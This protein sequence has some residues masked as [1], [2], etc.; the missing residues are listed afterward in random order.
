VAL[1][2]QAFE[3]IFTTHHETLYRYAF[4]ILRDE[5]SAEEAVS[6]VFCRLWQKRA[7]LPADSTLPGYVYSA[8][9]HEAMD[10][11]KHEEI[12][13]RHTNYLV[14]RSRQVRQVAEAAHRA[15]LNE[16]QQLLLQAL[17]NLPDQ[18]RLIFHLSRVEQL[19]HKDIAARLGLSIKTV[20]T[21]VGRAL[22]RLRI[23]LADYLPL[24]IIG[25]VVIAK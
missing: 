4:S 17:E 22:K 14:Y 13:K 10:Q 6:A 25:Y 1:S 15:E 18:C 8:V 3:E 5:A 20:E 23:A 9:H 19:S 7:T 12:R 11:L 16:F 21:Q 24:L 2:D